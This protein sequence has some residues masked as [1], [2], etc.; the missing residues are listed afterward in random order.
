MLRY[1]ILDFPFVPSTCLEQRLNPYGR[2]NHCTNGV[3]NKRGISA[4]SVTC[5]F[6]Y[7]IKSEANVIKC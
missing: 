1:Q 2:E 3:D 7:V 6:S 4:L 5:Y